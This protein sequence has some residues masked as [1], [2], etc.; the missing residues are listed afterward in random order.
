MNDKES[1]VIAGEAKQ[2]TLERMTQRILFLEQIL[3]SNRLQF[4][5]MYDQEFERLT[6]PI[7]K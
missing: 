7:A 5:I 1:E 6:Q 2:F 4:T 3:R